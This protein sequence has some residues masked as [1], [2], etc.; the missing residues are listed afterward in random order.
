[1]CV[2]ESHTKYVTVTRNI[3][4]WRG[5]PLCSVHMQLTVHTYTFQRLAILHATDWY[6]GCRSRRQVEMEEQRSSVVDTLRRS[7]QNDETKQHHIVIPAANEVRMHKRN[8]PIRVRGEMPSCRQL[9]AQPTSGLPA[10]LT[11]SRNAIAR[12][13]MNIL[14]MVY[15]PCCP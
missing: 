8:S 11:M 2:N 14:Y 10:S 7:R 5:L 1:M 12:M 15:A 9:P 3:E 4:E 13:L 6:T